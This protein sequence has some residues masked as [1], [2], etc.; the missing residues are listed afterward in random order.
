LKIYKVGVDQDGNVLWKREGKERGKIELKIL[1]VGLVFI[2]GIFGIFLLRNFSLKSK[3]LPENFELLRKIQIDKNQYLAI[4]QEITSSQVGF[5]LLDRKLHFKKWLPQ[6]DIL[7]PPQ[8]DALRGD[9]FEWLKRGDYNKDGVEEVVIQ[10]QYAGPARIH[11]FYLYQFKKEKSKLLLYL[12]DS[13]SET[14]LN[15]FNR[16]GIFEIEH[17]FSLDGTGVAGRN[18]T[19]WKEIWAWNGKEYQ[20]ANNLYPESC[21]DLIK[22][23]NDI[24]ENPPDEESMI[25]YRPIIECL[26]EKALLNQKEI[27]ADG[28]D[29]LKD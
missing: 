25:H 19:Q 28:R 24:L 18:L 14:K 8:K 12:E 17:T 22:F 5:A 11:L 20:K 9:H 21:S 1:L 26:K 10:T 3:N 2:L 16:D 4:F 23:Y 6:A 27:F 13:A 15:D 29:C 7:L